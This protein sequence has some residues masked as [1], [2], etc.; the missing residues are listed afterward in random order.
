MPNFYKANA[1]LASVVLTLA[2]CAAANARAIDYDTE[3]AA[4]EAKAREVERDNDHSDP[5][6]W[7]S[8]VAGV[9]LVFD[10]NQ[11]TRSRLSPGCWLTDDEW[12]VISR[13]GVELAYDD[14]DGL[15]RRS[16]VEAELFA[17]TVPMVGPGMTDIGFFQGFCLGGRVSLGYSDVTIPALGS[18][19]GLR[20]SAEAS[21]SIVGLLA[22]RCG[23]GYDA[24]LDGIDER[25][26]GLS[27]VVPAHLP[28]RLTLGYREISLGSGEIASFWLGLEI[29]IGMLVTN[30]NP[31][32]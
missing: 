1:F 10:D 8:L 19:Q 14:F 3:A 15:G 2:F 21:L 7:L 11:W 6:S 25:W 32:K 22:L 30:P 23:Y 18:D 28:S 12:V 13:V 27:V 4:T 29:D 26:V 16:S 5:D 24:A 17:M 31:L 9:D 20:A